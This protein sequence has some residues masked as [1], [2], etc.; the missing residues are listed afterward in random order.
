[1]LDNPFGLASKGIFLDFPDDGGGLWIFLVDDI[2]AFIFC[3]FS[4]CYFAFGYHP[5]VDFVG[6]IL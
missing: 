5:F 1:L 2:L 3:S 6:K 4:S